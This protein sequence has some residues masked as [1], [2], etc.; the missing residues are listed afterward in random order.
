MLVFPD[1]KA[2]YY[3]TKEQEAKCFDVC[4]QT[5]QEATDETKDD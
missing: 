3:C 5:R 4:Y 1:G 2:N